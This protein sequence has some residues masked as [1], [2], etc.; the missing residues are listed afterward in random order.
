M[1]RDTEVKYKR[2]TEDIYT[3]QETDKENK[4]K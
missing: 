2:A 1:Q 4:N 3:L